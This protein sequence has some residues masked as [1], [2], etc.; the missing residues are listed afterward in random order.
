MPLVNGTLTDFGLDP[1]TINSPVLYFRASSTGIAGLNILSK[2]KAVEAVPAANGF[3]EVDL[4]AT[5]AVAPADTHYMIEIRY[6]DS[7]GMVVSESLPWKL[8]VPSE[9]GALGDLLRV[10]ANPAL[11][12]TGTEP[13]ELATAGL[14]WLDPETGDLSEFTGT[15]WQHKANLRGPAGYNAT[16]AAGSDAAIAAFIGQNGSATR[17]KLLADFVSATAGGTQIISAV[18][19]FTGQF[20]GNQATL[21]GVYP[22]AQ[23]ATNA[24]LDLATGTSNW[25]IDNDN[26]KLRFLLASVAEK[27]SITATNMV[28]RVGL[29][30]PML[31][32]SGHGANNPRQPV[33]FNL[34]MNGPTLTDPAHAKVDKVAQVL[35]VTAT[36]DY[37]PEFSNGSQ[38]PG[39]LWAANDFFWTG[40]AAGDIKGIKDLWSRLTEVHLRAP[41]ADLNTIVGFQAEAN[42]SVAAAAARAKV[43]SIFAG[44][45]IGPRLNGA[46]DVTNAYTVYITAPSVDAAAGGTAPTGVSE[47]LHVDGKTTI[48]GDVQVT[49][50]LDVR[51]A[52]LNRPFKVAA[53]A[54]SS[55]TAAKGAYLGLN[56]AGLDNPGMELATGL[57]SGR[58]DVGGNLLRFLKTNTHV[59]A[60]I[61]LDTRKF[62]G[63]GTAEFKGVVTAPGYIQAVT[64][65]A[66]NFTATS[67]E[68]VILVT[69][70]ATITL[71]DPVSR[72]GRTFT[73]KNTSAAAAVT[74][75]TAAGTIDTTAA[76]PGQALR[77]VSDGAGWIS[78]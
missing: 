54:P 1:L 72:R 62:T 22:S 2:R 39:F 12:F 31:G 9:G 44:R 77:F 56:G 59:L 55:L 27:L 73:V 68:S 34:T 65:V 45:F 61:D 52:G 51:N 66:G 63:E 18:K 74:V 25:R 35:A 40:T 76:A 21:Q 23:G 64:T 26:G 41:G 43:A 50:G 14:W 69:A 8:F 75:A 46:A 10:P 20:F 49:G 48:N 36:G 11:V 15:G 7:N 37:T 24:G 33:G 38:T 19:R 57:T 3:F 60:S 67:A 6:R 71:P 78:I 30:A 17:N 42:I 16:D 28:V 32:I 13:P 47:A 5:A 58:V 29:T 53:L 4:V 70:A